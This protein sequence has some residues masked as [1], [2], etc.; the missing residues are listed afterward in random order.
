[1]RYKNLTSALRRPSRKKADIDGRGLGQ[2][3]TAEEEQ[4]RRENAL[5]FRSGAANLE[6]GQK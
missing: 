4:I 3:Q 1:M 5:Q 2:S 6:N